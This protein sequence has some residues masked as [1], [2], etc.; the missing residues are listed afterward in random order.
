MLQDLLLNIASELIGIVVT[1]FF[2]DR[3]LKAREQNRILPSRQIVY[4]WL[5]EE[6]A[7]LLGPVIISNLVRR[8]S[9]GIASRHIAYEFGAARAYC[10]DISSG[11]DKPIF[12]ITDT[13]AVNIQNTVSSLRNIFEI[14]NA[15]SFL[16]ESELI[17]LLLQLKDISERFIVDNNPMFAMGMVHDAFDVCEWLIQRSTKKITSDEL[18][19]EVDRFLQK[20]RARNEN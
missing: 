4:A 11:V 5:L 14:L 10:L 9:S 8:Q 1:V 17:R 15:K 6:V 19:S 7:N 12:A 13:K 16:M 20:S 2:V 18:D 3:L